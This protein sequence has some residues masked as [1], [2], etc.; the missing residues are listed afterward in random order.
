[1][2]PSYFVIVGILLSVANLALAGFALTNDP[3]E[4]W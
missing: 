4:T 3:S 1:M 2:T